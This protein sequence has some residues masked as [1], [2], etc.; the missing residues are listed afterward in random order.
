MRSYPRDFSRFFEFSQRPGTTAPTATH[1]WRPLATVPRPAAR[2]PR[3][4]RALAWAGAPPAPPAASES[5]PHP[6]FASPPGLSALL[7]KQGVGGGAFPTPRTAARRPRRAREVPLSPGA[8]GPTCLCKQGARGGQKGSGRGRNR[9]AWGGARAKN[10]PYARTLRAH[11]DGGGEGHARA[12]HA[13]GTRT[14]PGKPG[15]GE[16]GLPGAGPDLGLER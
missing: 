5:P 9:N 13:R 12:P 6:T 11:A 3:T 8:L 10:G 15:G 14:K 16:G 1:A 4:G 7:S 2:F